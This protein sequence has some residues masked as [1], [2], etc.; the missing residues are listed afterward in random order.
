MKDAN[1]LFN[2]ST[3]HADLSQT[4]SPALEWIVSFF[5]QRSVVTT[6][7]RKKERGQKERKGQNS[8]TSKDTRRQVQARQEAQQAGTT[9]TKKSKTQQESRQQQHTCGEA[10]AKLQLSV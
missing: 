6:P 7:V 10:L 1:G 4:I 3:D 5:L 9:P 8:S 2:L